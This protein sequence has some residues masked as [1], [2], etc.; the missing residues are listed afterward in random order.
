MA[1]SFATGVLLFDEDF[2]LPSKPSEPE[3]I[4]PV[5]TAAEL[6]AAREEAAQD[7]R[8][9]AVAE[10]EGSIRAVSSR[11]LAEIAAQ[12]VATRDEAATIAEQ[13]A[14]AIARLLL[15][16][17][18][19]A[20][21]VLSARHGAG[22]LG[23]VL[24]EILPALHREPKI[25][26]RVNPQLIAVVTEEIQALDSDLSARVRLIPTDGVALGDMR[27]AWEHGAATRD[28]ASLWSQIESVLAP[29][30]L[31]DVKQTVKEH[32]LVE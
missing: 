18:A 17:F 28:A 24:R 7:G 11:A 3:V 12:L 15:D 26:I 21:P 25:S 8:D 13:S 1:R 14:E 30:G 31:L 20:F 27:I 29:T 16:C 22:E 2:D 6:M 23:A 5:F 4:D 9:R 32:E 10:A 19:A